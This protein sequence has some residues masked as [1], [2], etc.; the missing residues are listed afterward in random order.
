MLKGVVVEVFTQTSQLLSFS[1]ERPMEW[2][3][4][5]R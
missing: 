3:V 1:H 5:F 4:G 2:I